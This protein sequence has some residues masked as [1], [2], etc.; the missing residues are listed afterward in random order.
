[1]DDHDIINNLSSNDA[2]AILQQLAARD[3]KL[4]GEIAALA[5]ARLSDVDMDE[6]A[7][8]LRHKLESLEPE[9]VWERA[10]TTRSGYV[11]TSEAAF[12]L[13]EELLEPHL[14]EVRR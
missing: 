3:E 5:R 10:G 2:L 13:L 1:M 11:H 14:D 8:A 12:E 4:A 7:R 9:D 6:V